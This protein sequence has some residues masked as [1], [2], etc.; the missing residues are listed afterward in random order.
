MNE[1]LDLPVTRERLDVLRDGSLISDAEFEDMLG[2][3]TAT[4]DV[5]SWQRF[6]ALA[7][8]TAGAVLVAAGVLFFVAYDWAALHR[9]EKLALV[10]SA[11]GATTLFGIVR[12]DHRSGKAALSLSTILVGA[13]LAVFGQV[14]QTGADTWQLFASWAALALP[15]VLFAR[16]APLYVLELALID[17]SL[18]LFV[19]VDRRYGDEETLVLALGLVNGLAWLAAE[20]LSH[21]GT[22]GLAGRALSRV[23][24]CFAF[25]PLVSGVVLFVI[26]EA[27][28]G[29]PLITTALFVVAVAA[30]VYAHNVLRRDLFTLTVLAASLLVVFATGLAR[31]LF[32]AL[33]LD[34]LGFLIEGALLVGAVGVAV[35]VLRA[36]AL[37][38]SE[39]KR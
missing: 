36:Q 5:A 17:L 24:C 29:A 30:T 28:G 39:V 7:L 23:L 16:T 38:G 10:A 13:L 26:D 37:M 8:L 6:I 25:M 11:L 34:E 4:P 3:A 14:Y 33:D 2:L 21:R 35:H 15:F 22:E 9:L 20:V 1:P 31:V 32:D 27:E 19:D 12:I 18:M